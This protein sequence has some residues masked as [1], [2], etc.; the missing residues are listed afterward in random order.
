MDYFIASDFDGTIADTFTPSPRG[1][2]VNEAY[3]LACNEVFGNPQGSRLFKKIGGIKNA[4]PRNLIKEILRA[5]D[6]QSLVAL[7]KES[8]LKNGSLEGY[9]PK[10]KGFSFVWDD[11]NP[12]PVITEL[13]VRIKLK[14]LIAEIRGKGDAMWPKPCPG[15]LLFWQ[16]LSMFNKANLANELG[17]TFGIL[18]SGHDYFI[19][20]TFEL[21]EIYPPEHMITDDYLRSN[22]CCSL[23]SRERV[24]PHPKT[25][26]LLCG[27]RIKEGS[28]IYAGDC[29]KKDGSLARKLKLCFIW[30]NLDGNKANGFDGQLI[31]IKSWTE[32]NPLFGSKSTEMM[33]EKCPFATIARTILTP[34]S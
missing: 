23:K 19:Q 15:F 3:R 21:W 6:R 27:K 12:I 28:V 24:K 26:E 20:K 22:T 30:M 2:G 11:E 16:A 9:V 14:I 32:L 10:G 31:S 29:L 18:S 1:I 7:A 33:I 13:L 17:I 34:S 8:F 4:A 25:L 5:G